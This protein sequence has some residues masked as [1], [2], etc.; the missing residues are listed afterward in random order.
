MIVSGSFLFCFHPT[1]RLGR[2]KEKN[3]LYLK[4][5]EPENLQISV[6]DEV[7]RTCGRIDSEREGWGGREGREGGRGGEG[8]FGEKGA[9]H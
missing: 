3:R 6:Q 5:N 2:K 9:L 4:L 8:D 1:L 7:G